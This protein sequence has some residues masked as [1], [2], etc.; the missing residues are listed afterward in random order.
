VEITWTSSGAVITATADTAGTPFTLTTSETA[1]TGTIGDYVAVTA[2]KS[3]ND[4]ND[5]VNWSAG[6]VPA[7][8]ENIYFDETSTVPVYW[9]LSALSSVTPTSVTVTAGYTGTIGL[10]SING[11]GTAYPEYRAKY[12][13]FDSLV[14]GSTMVIGGGIGNCSGLLRFQLGST[15]I[16]TITVFNTSSSTETARQ[17]LSIYGPST[18]TVLTHVGGYLGIAELAGETM[19]VLTTN[20]GPA[21]LGGSTPDLILSVGC[22]L[23][24]VNI[25]DAQLRL[26]AAATTLNAKA[27]SIYVRGSGAITTITIGTATVQHQGTGTITTATIS[28]GGRLDMGTAGPAITITNVLQMFIGSNYSDQGFRATLSAGFKANGCALSEVNVNVGAGRTFT[29]A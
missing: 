17:A 3:P 29:P 10:K 15:G 14:G 11:F 1:G 9:N 26:A 22:T 23:T 21:G 2:N 4:F 19:T 6:T 24:T 25:D 12:L 27:G 5:A 7:N 8:S 20:C 16:W 28:S 13:R 18:N